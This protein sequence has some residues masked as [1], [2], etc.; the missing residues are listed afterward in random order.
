M[1]RGGS[2]KGAGRKQGGSTR[3]NQAAREQALATGISP[4]DY[5]LKMLRDPDLPQAE[6][7]EAAKAAAP[8]VHARL[9]NVE[10]K[11]EVVHRFVARV[12][13]K[14]ADPNAWQKQ[15]APKIPTIQ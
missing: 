1:A 11:S 8:Y 4:L 15:H 9:S 6:R 5:M 12:P 13:N 10:S 14:A 3:V 2:R 7:F